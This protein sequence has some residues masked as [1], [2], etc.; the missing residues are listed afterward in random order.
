[1]V[2]KEKVFHIQL[3]TKEQICTKKCVMPE[4]RS[5][6]SY[7]RAARLSRMEKVGADMA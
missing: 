5:R 2:K 6:W 7:I 4:L 3:L 1:M